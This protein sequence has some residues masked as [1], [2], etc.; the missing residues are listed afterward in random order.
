MDTRNKT[1][2]CTL[3]QKDYHLGVAALLNSLIKA[4]YH[5][6]FYIGFNE[7]LPPW[8]DQLKKVSENVYQ[9]H[10]QIDVHFIALKCTMHY[11]FYKPFFMKQLIEKYQKEK[12]YYFDPDICVIANWSFFE[13]WTNFGISL[14][15][16]NCY[17]Y[18]AYNHLWR[19]QWIENFGA[20]DANF[21]LDKNLNFYVNSGFIG[22]KKEN[23]PLIDRWIAVTNQYI[24]TGGNV[25]KF[26]KDGERDVKGDQ[27]L[28]N[29]AITLLPD[30][31]YSIIGTE[32]MG[33]SQPAYLMTHAIAATKPWQKN[34]TSDTLLNASRPSILEKNFFNHIEH[35]I[36]VFST[37]KRLLKKFDILFAS[38]LGRIIS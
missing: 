35:P 9:L 11:G 30:L 25:Q 37:F 2:I 26:E 4:G 19:N 22:L 10:D 12:F 29:A 18:L 31:K 32:G 20:S 14:C 34:F 24:E 38:L 27:D 17:P 8:I 5:G 23:M 15:L 1:G 28:L 21:E 16:D 7:A 33:F 6:D 13:K 3:Y 36:L